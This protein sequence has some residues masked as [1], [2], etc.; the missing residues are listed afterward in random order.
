MAPSFKDF[1]WIVFSGK[2]PQLARHVRLISAFVK[3]ANF[4]YVHWYVAFG[5]HKAYTDAEACNVQEVGSSV[6]AERPIHR[7]LYIGLCI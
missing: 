6:D 2:R 3:P 5:D 7:V 1:L 4:K